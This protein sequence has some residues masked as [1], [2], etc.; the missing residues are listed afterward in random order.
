MSTGEFVPS[1]TQIVY[2]CLQNHVAK[3]ATTNI[4]IDG[5]W[6]DEAPDC[7]PFCNA[8]AITGVSFFP[9]SCKLNDVERR[10]GKPAEPGTIVR[11]NCRDRYERHIQAKQQVVA[12]GDDGLWASLPVPCTPICGEPASIDKPH[13]TP[14]VPWHV[15]IY[16]RNGDNDDFRCGGTIINER[17]IVSAMS[18]FWNPTENKP[19]DVSEF[20]VIAGKD[21]YDSNTHEDFATKTLEIENI[22]GDLSYNGA[23]ANYTADIVIIV[24]KSYIEFDSHIGPICVT[25][26]STMESRMSPVSKHSRV[27]GWG[28]TRANGSTGPGRLGEHLKMVELESI[29]RQKCIDGTDSAFR[30]RVTSD[31]FCAGYADSDIS[32]C[33]SDSG[34]G[35]VLPSHERKRTVY[36]LR[37]VASAGAITERNCD[38]NKYA[39]F[40]DILHYETLIQTYEQRYRPK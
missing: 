31:K 28:L 10:C 6:R 12:C 32:V 34:G 19:F 26:G 21:Q 3:G 2:K 37:G 27:A 7:N 18:C 29:D 38:V 33:P 30:S 15:A 16:K 23:S 11:I 14:R 25:Y 5:K 22:F 13:S 17:V 36:Y 9:I 20:R 1:L 39:T 8:T 35:L 4:C 24:L 40:T